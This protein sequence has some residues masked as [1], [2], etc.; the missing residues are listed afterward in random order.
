[1]AMAVLPFRYGWSG[2]MKI[3]LAGGM[4]VTNVKGRERACQPLPYLEKVVFFL[5]LKLHSK[6]RDYSNQ[7]RGKHA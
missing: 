5:F 7:T 4:T 3:Y 6:I 1:M 2:V